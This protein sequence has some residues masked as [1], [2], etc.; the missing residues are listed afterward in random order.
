MSCICQLLASIRLRIVKNK[1]SSWLSTWSGTGPKFSPTRSQYCKK[2]AHKDR[3]HTICPSELKM[4]DMPSRCSTQCSPNSRSC[5]LMTSVSIVV[6]CCTKWTQQTIRG[7]VMM[8]LKDQVVI[9]QVS[10]WTMIQRTPKVEAAPTKINQVRLRKVRRVKSDSARL[11]SSN[12]KDSWS[13]STQRSNRWPLIITAGR[14]W[15]SLHSKSSLKSLSPV[16]KRNRP[17]IRSSH[18]VYTS[19]WACQWSSTSRIPK[20]PWLSSWE[21]SHEYVA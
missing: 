6:T 19:T 3:L 20:L 8:C 12:S 2:D 7:M 5:S 4:S 11:P 10:Y 1:W 21:V 15:P 9:L 17:S 16:W 18:L 13:K 14:T